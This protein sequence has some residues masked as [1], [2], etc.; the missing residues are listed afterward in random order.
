[1][2]THSKTQHAVDRK[3]RLARR[4]RQAE[5]LRERLGPSAPAPKPRKPSRH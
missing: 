4:R 1:M 3:R 2:A 5:V